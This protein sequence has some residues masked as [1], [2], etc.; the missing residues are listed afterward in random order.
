MAIPIPEKLKKARKDLR[1]D[2]RYMQATEKVIDDHRKQI[3]DLID[4]APKLFF[5]WVI[6]KMKKLKEIFWKWVD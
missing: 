2:K 1:E 5:I 3:K 4:N 6:E